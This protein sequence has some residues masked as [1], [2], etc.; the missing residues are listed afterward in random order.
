MSYCNISI[1]E[2]T[3]DDLD[4][5]IE[6]EEKCFP[7]TQRYD[8]MIFLHFHRKDPDLFI[9][10]EY[11]GHVVGYAIGSIENS[12]G[13][14]VSL[15]VHPCCRKR[16]IGSRLLVEIEN[17]LIK[18]GVKTILLEVAVTNKPAIN[19]YLKHGYIPIRIIE[20]YYGEEDAYLMIKQI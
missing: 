5:V 17:R 9:I 6:I 7:P 16:G 15:A 12:R 3:A 20:K 14:I 1:R 19:L 4:S 8:P 10:A 2:F 13:H 11:C 18:R